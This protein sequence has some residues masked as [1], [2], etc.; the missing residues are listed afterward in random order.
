MIVVEQKPV[1]EIQRMIAP[2]EK[3]MILGCGTCVIGDDILTGGAHGTKNVRNSTWHHHPLR[4]FLP[5]LNNAL[6]RI[7]P[8][9]SHNRHG[10]GGTSAYD[11]HICFLHCVSPNLKY[12]IASLALPSGKL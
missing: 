11:Y 8:L 3:V 7:M 12:F 5:D 9:G 10:S 2:Y 1:D 6:I 4:L